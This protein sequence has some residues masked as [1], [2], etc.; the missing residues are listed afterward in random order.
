MEEKGLI[1]NV[2]RF[3]TEDGDGIR[4]TVFF[5]GCPLHC[6]WCHN[7]ESQGFAPQ[8][9][10]DSDACI[11]CGACEAV[12]KE[13]CHA[14]KAREAHSFDRAPCTSC[15]L[16]TDACP[17]GALAVIGKYRTAKEVLQE[18]LKDKDYY[19][20]NGGITLSGGEP[21]AQ[22]QF[23]IALAKAA[24]DA[25][26]N[27]CI[28]TSGYCDMRVLE[29]ILP[30]VDCFLFDYKC[31]PEDYPSLVGTDFDPIHEN[32]AFLCANAKRVVLRCPIVPECIKEDHLESI[33]HLM[34]KFSLTE[35][36]LLPYHKLGIEKCK[37]LG[38]PEQ[39][40]FTEPNK[41][42]LLSIARALSEKYGVRITVK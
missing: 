34:Q 22:P 41:N 28:E 39:R 5:K 11:L 15:G 17:T 24:K 13:H 25:G 7:P 26:M 18:A 16:C 8:I 29:E 31:E 30:F 19:G 42:E 38:R 9:Y 40:A 35:A 3:C 23:A 36:E 32:L 1:F 2:Q 12:C 37:R 27:V 14:V 20:T 10:F 21:L 6:P 4:T 33:G